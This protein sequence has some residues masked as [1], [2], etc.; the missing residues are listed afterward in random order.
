MRCVPHFRQFAVG[1]LLLALAGCEQSSVPTAEEIE[2]PPVFT[3]KPFVGN[4]T[5]SD[6]LQPLPSK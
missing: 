1:V 2:N 5:K 6:S 4:G 3:A